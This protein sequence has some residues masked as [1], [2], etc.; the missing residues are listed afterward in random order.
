M[1]Y[2]KKG[3]PFTSLNFFGCFVVLRIY[4][5]ETNR[6]LLYFRWMAKAHREHS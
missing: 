3:F 2:F 6:V 4:E 5:F 1:G